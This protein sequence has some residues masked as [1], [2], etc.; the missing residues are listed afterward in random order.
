MRS[1]RYITVLEDHL[2]DHFEIHRC[3][4]FMQD[5]AP[6]HTALRVKDFFRDHNI[7]LLDWP[8][9]SPDLNPIENAWNWMKDQLTTKDT[10]SFPRLVKELKDLWVHCDGQYFKKL[11]SSMPNRLR[12]VLKAKG[13]MTKY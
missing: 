11:A 5:K 9:N 7:A 3:S 13:Q 10:S 6:C 1:E 2:L 4:F 12:K 8:G